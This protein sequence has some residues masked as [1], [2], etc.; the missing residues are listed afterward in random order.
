MIGIQAYLQRILKYADCSS[1]CYVIILVYFDRLAM[2]HKDCFLTSKNVHRM[3]ITSI[4][5]AAKVRDDKYYNNQHYAAIGGITATEMNHLELQLLTLLDFNLFVTPEAYQ[6]YE[7][8][9]LQFPR[10]ERTDT[11]MSI[12]A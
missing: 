9:L 1:E 2:A 12:R 3:L 10:D 8:N 5:L 11:F 7:R 4:L 6:Q